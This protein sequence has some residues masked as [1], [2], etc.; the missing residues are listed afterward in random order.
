MGYPL[1]WTDRL[2]PPPPPLPNHQ[3]LWYKESSAAVPFGTLVA[4]VAL[5]FCISV[6]LVSEPHQ[7]C[8]IASP[9]P[10]TPHPTLSSPPCLHHQTFLGAYL[11]FKK[12]VIEQPVRTNQI[13]RQIPPQAVYTRPLASILMGGVL[14]FGCVFIQLFFIL[15]SIWFV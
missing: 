5:W 10:L 4:L 3:V 7:K 13:P 14:P 2:C 6:P 12:P 1:S 11:G 15:N 8:L 9:S